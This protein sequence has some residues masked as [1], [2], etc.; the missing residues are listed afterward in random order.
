MCG[1]CCAHVPDCRISAFLLLLLFF[2][3][4]AFF[5]GYNYGLVRGLLSEVGEVQRS[6]LTDRYVRRR[7][8]QNVTMGGQPATPLQAVGAEVLVV[9]VLG[10]FL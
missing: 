2:N 3:T 10:H 1:L 5:G 4:P 7:Q 8:R 6:K 9:K